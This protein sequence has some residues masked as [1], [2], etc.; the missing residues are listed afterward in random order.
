MSKI[1][2]KVLSSFLIITFIFNTADAQKMDSKQEDWVSLFNGKNLDGWDIK[3]AG[4]KLNDN[5]KNTFRAEDSMLRIVY[6]DYK[7]FDD[8]YGH[9]YYKK[10]YSYYILRYQY[11]F[12]GNQTPGG[13]TWNV[14]NSGV[15]IHSQSAKSLTIN[16]NFPVSLEVQLLGGLGTG[17]R[18]TGNV[19]TPGTQV[20]IDGK[21]DE[22]HCIDSKSKTYN[23]DQW[24]S[25]TVVLLGGSVIKHI[26][27]GDTVLT[28]E[29]PEVGGG[30]VSKDADWKWGHV[31][32]YQYWESRQNTPLK[33][34]YIA[35]QAESH[36]IDFR[37]I[38]ILN[39]EG[40]TDKKAKNYKD[41]YVKSDNKQCRY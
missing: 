7:T 13:E 33:E 37:R 10:P 5:Y 1:N 21:L 41:Y 26:V 4:Q 20:H 17:E 31:D 28:Y 29:K 40:C 24:V 27:E 36:P 15:M 2:I 9:L 38:E 19:C 6:D 35:L 11:R 3:I 39:L 16:Q 22:A 32:N 25:M 14:R 23:G 18:H 34:G 8:K 12:R 30:F